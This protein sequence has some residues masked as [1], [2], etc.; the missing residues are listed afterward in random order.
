MLP[1]W[2]R[3]SP[4][5]PPVSYF[6]SSRERESGLV[7]LNDDGDQALGVLNVDGLDVAVELLL[8]VLLVVSAAA[9]AHAQSVRN[10]LDALLPDLLVEL[11]VQADVGG[12]LD[13]RKLRRLV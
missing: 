11:G 8:G 9:D 4:P 2:Y 3:L 10:A 7:L 12:A 5:R 13:M 1:H 6:R